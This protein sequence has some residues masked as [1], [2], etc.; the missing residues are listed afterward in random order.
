MPKLKSNSGALKRFSLTKKG[1]I[2]KKKAN[3]SHLLTHKARK[4][5]RQLRRGDYI[6]GGEA[7]HIKRLL[8]YL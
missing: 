1:K 5:K 7:K 3:L 4:R 6:T 8:P 2:K